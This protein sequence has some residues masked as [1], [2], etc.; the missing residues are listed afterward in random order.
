MIKYAKDTFTP[1]ELNVNDSVDFVL[2]SGKTVKIKILRTGASVIRTTLKEL[3]VEEI[4]ARTD[5]EF[6]C[7]AEVGKTTVIMRR[8]V[9]TQASFYEPWTVNGVTIWLDAVDDIFDFLFETHGPC[10]PKK[11]VRLAIQDASLGICPEKLHP[12]CPLPDG[13]LRIE[14]CYRGED[15]WLGAYHGVSAH[16]GLDLNHQ[17]G[18]P[19][20]AP[21]DIDDQYYVNSLAMGHNNNRW[22]GIH[23][24]P[25]GS[26]WIFYAAHMT[27]LTVPEHQPLKK[28]TQFA[29]G[30]GVYSGDMHH[31]HFVFK[32]REDGD[33]FLLDPWILFR[34]M[35]LDMDF[36]KS[37]I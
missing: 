26:E 30:A 13:G 34:Q 16:G 8:E 10:R 3:K 12:W 27:S 18:T 4:R 5:Y 25:D 32:V 20:W 19:L 31:S 11:K 29:N 36:Q 22:E 28:G 15:C 6:F 21:L 24:W 35:Y 37:A 17:P 7:E 9:S 2:R 33:T 23:R 14:M 1:L